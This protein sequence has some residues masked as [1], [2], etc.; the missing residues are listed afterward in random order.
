MGN[1]IKKLSINCGQQS[2]PANMKEAVDTKPT[3]QEQ[4]ELVDEAGS[5]ASRRW[6]E[7]RLAVVGQLIFR[8]VEGGQLSAKLK[9][10][11]AT[12]W[13]HPITGK[14][15]T[16][17]YGSQ[18]VRHHLFVTAEPKLHVFSRTEPAFSSASGFFER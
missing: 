4:P 13:K 1:G 3:N 12:K 15:V 16:F 14:S 6:A 10:L 18:E 2:V 5:D 7:F 17:G 8:D 9:S 11:S